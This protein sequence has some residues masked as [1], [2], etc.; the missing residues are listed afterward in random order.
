MLVL[1]PPKKYDTKIVYGN[2]NTIYKYKGITYSTKKSP[3]EPYLFLRSKILGQCNKVRKNGKIRYLFNNFNDEYLFAVSNTRHHSSIYIYDIVKCYPNIACKIYDFETPLKKTVLTTE[4]AIINHLFGSFAARKSVYYYNDNMQC[5][6]S[7]ILENKNKWIF[8]TIVSVLNKINRHIISDDIG[9]LLAVYYDALYFSHYIGISFCI[10]YL[11][12]KLKFKLKRVLNDCTI[13]NNKGL[14]RL[15][16]YYYEDGKNNMYNLNF[17]H[18]A[19]SLNN[20]IIY[21]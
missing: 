13:I 12:I 11:G 2:G 1:E 17:P 4:K 21:K 15:T 10:D 6:H 19:L 7:E 5:T 3:I 16:G 9:H 8:F 18:Y 14:E 20:S